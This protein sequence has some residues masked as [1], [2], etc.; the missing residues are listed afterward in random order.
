MDGSP[1]H[2]LSKTCAAC[3][4]NICYDVPYQYGNELVDRMQEVSPP[5]AEFMHSLFSATNLK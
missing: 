2:F 3:T 4:R 5:K 1:E